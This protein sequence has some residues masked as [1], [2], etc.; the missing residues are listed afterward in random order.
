MAPLRLDDENIYRARCKNHSFIL[1]LHS[2]CSVC[3][4]LPSIAL[5]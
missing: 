4:M 1:Y 2:V 5:E 3:G